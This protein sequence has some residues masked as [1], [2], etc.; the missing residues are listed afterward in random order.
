MNWLNHCVDQCHQL[1]VNL[2]T[3]N[4]QLSGKTGEG[5][6]AEARQLRYQ[7]FN[8]QLKTG[9]LL[10]M[11][12]H[13]DDQIETFFLR[14]LRGSGVSGLSAMPETRALDYGYL[15]RPFL[16]LSK[17]HLETYANEHQLSWI[18]DES[19]ANNQFDRNFLRN[20][21]LPLIST[22]WPMYRKTLQRSISMLAEINSQQGLEVEPEI[23][24]RLT[25]NNGLIVTGLMD[26]DVSLTKR[27]LRAWIQSQHKLPPSQKQLESIIETVINARDD[28]QPM[29]SLKDYCIRRYRSELFITPHLEEPDTEHVAVE[30]GETLDISGIGQLTAKV[31]TLQNS[32]VDAISLD[33]A[34][35][36]IRFHYLGAS[37]KPANR[38]KS[39]D[40]KRLLQEY[41]VKPWIRDRLPLIYSGE[42]LVAVADLFVVDGFQALAGD[43]GIKIHWQHPDS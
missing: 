22:R 29:M 31:V 17:S 37:I 30:V 7:A 41:Q 1:N 42:Q 25:E 20:Q 26:M 38:N 12:H 35:L 11:G 16:T 23:Q 40:L 13:L 27:L 32:Q 36:T 15:G 8:T 43:Q 3:V 34:P 4:I 21:V 2:Q 10:L 14:L 18:E 24:Y 39:R 5:I 9:D 33:C 6:E 19:N 28:A